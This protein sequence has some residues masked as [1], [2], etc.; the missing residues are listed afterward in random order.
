MSAEF[1]PEAGQVGAARHFAAAALRRWSIVPDDVVLVVSELAT[2]AVQHGRSPFT[3]ALC[4]D[5]HRVTVEVADGNPRLPALTEPSPQAL[6][7]RG[8][9][10]VERIASRWGVRSS[11]S[12]KL[13]WAEVEASPL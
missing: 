3:V 7:G 8:L 5:G 1:R 11:Q 10:M 12:G 13:V 2:N 4:A 9:M 6:S